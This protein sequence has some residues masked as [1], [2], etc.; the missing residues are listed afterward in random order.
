MTSDR[1]TFAKNLARE[2]GVII[3]QGYG[4]AEEIH[5]KGVIDLV[6]EYDLRS[7]RFVVER[8]QRA[9]PEDAIVAE[10]G[11][12]YNEGSGHW[13]LDPLDGT[14]NFAH[15]V[16]V[17]CISLAY[18]EDGHLELGVIYDPLRDDLFHVRRGEGAWLGDQR[19]HVS[20]VKSLNQSLLATGF[21]Y[22]IRTRIDNNLDHFSH[23]ALRTQGVRR[24]GSAALDLAYVAAGRF[25]GYWE[26]CSFPWDIAAGTLMVTEAN[27]VVTRAAGDRIDVSRATSIV[28]TNG[29]IHDELIEVLAGGILPPHEHTAAPKRPG[30]K[31]S[32]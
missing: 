9:F 11:G 2:A 15:G 25:E 6:T 24:L 16:P 1:Y 30:E 23:L 18:M 8:L 5:K 26:M 31:R 7:E 29:N 13:F 3:R 27:G 14:V 21:S 4:N 28:A 12:E 19:L 17:F 32:S 10:E 20:S 22:D